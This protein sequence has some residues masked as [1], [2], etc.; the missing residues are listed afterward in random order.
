MG[1]VEVKD[2]DV[3]GPGT[4][5]IGPTDAPGNVDK[6]FT[7][8]NKG[9]AIEAQAWGAEQ[10]GDWVEKETASIGPDGSATLKVEHNT[11]IQVKL[12]AN[13]VDPTVP[14]KVDAVLEWDDNPD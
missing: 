8:H 14:G 11:H 9:G 7:V 10:G 5:I 1:K 3:P 6:V 12:T 4:E 2:V 13:P